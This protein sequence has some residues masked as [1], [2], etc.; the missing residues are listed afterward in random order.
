MGG[1]T[2]SQVQMGGT[3]FPG[4]GGGGYPIPGSGGGY[5]LPRCRWGGTP[6]Q[7]QVGGYPIQGPGRGHPS[8]VPPTPSRGVH[9]PRVPPSRGRPPGVPPTPGRGCPSGV[10]PSRGCPPGVPPS[11]GAPAQGTPLPAGGAR[12][13]YPPPP[14][15]EQHSVYLLRGGRYVSCVHAGG[16]S[17]LILCVSPHCGL[18][19]A[20]SE[21][22]NGPGSAAGAMPLAVSRRRT[23]L[24]MIWSMKYTYHK[25]N[26]MKENSRINT[27]PL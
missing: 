18:F 19:A 26:V 8:R 3:P 25:E 16:L 14:Q 9:L 4:A 10:P 7:V 20:R 5:P 27:V 12:P 24:L 22:S 6:S 1:G 17:C 11:R 2:P 23:F 13:G 15:Q 21:L